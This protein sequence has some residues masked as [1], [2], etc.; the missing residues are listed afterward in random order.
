M[1]EVEFKRCYNETCTL[2]DGVQDAATKRALLLMLQLINGL[3][4]RLDDMQ[5]EDDD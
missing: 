4:V 5:T 1:D 2:V 3:A